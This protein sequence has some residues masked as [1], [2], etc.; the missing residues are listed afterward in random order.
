MA[1]RNN[2]MFS[3]FEHSKYM[4]NCLEEPNEIIQQPLNIIDNNL[5]ITHFSPLQ[6]AGFGDLHKSS[7]GKPDISLDALP[8]QS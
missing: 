7:P 3:C 6:K 5:K 4:S 1:K 8:M 2:S